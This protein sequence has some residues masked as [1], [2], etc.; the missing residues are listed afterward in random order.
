[1][2]V[3]EKLGIERH[4]F[5]RAAGQIDFENFLRKEIV[6]IRTCVAVALF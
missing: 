5:R 1:M 4:R 3:D 2:S 6:S